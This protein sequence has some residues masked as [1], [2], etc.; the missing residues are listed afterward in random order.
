[1]EKRLPSGG[2]NLTASR[3][4]CGIARSFDGFAVAVRLGLPYA[5]FQ[6]HTLFAKALIPPSCV[7]RDK[8]CGFPG[9]PSWTGRTFHRPAAMGSEMPF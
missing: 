5:P 4:I 8:F 7:V 2:L 6:F 9:T 3:P 1:M